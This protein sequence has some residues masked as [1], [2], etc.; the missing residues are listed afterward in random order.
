M[1]MPVISHSDTTICQALVDMAQSIAMEEAAI[2]HILNAEGEK[3]Q[4]MLQ[5]PSI[6]IKEMIEINQSVNCM[7]NQLNEFEQILLSK[8]DRLDIPD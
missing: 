6:T 7:V 5:L 1:G 2:A 4:K 8:L 3:I